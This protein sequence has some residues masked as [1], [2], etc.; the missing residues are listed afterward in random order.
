ML[1]SICV[2]SLVYTGVVSML[3]YLFQPSSQ[4]LFFG[5]YIYGKGLRPI[6]EKYNHLFINPDPG[7]RRPVFR[8]LRH[9]HTRFGRPRR[10]ARFGVCPGPGDKY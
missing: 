6:S 10:I 9:A 4:L 5:G 2:D 7:Y 1:K 8:A 3:A